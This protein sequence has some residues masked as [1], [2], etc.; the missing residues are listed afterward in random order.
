M[1]RYVQGFVICNVNFTVELK[2]KYF[3]DDIPAN[4]GYR[5]QG[6]NGG[7]SVNPIQTRG[8]D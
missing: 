2:S 1:N 8:T 6:A 7:R 4:Q 3:H 5:S